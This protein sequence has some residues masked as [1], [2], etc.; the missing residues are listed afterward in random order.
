MPRLMNKSASIVGATVS[1]FGFTTKRTDELTASEYT[2][3]HIGIDLSPSTAPYL[4][5]LEKTLG[6]AVESLGK[7]PR[8]DNMLVRVETF[9]ETLSEVHGFLPL[10]DITPKDYR[11]TNTGC[12]TALFDEMLAAVEAVGEYGKTLNGLDYGVNGVVFVLT[13]GMENQS[14]VARDPAKILEA[15]RA[16]QEAEQ[17]ESLK[18]VLIG[19]GDEGHVKQYLEGV[20]VSAGYDQYIWG[21]QL[22]PASLAKI[23]N[24]VSRSVSSASQSLGTGGPSANLNF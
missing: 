20:K 15:I 17:L 24:F 22:T 14:H 3:A 12:G 9:S 1:N 5:D 16:V 2:L 21:G 10:A 6:V 23:A 4:A 11:L 19:V 8:A 13:D 7:S 18:T